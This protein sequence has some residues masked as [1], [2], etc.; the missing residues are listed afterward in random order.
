MSVFNVYS[1]KCER[2]Q[3]LC[4]VPPDFGFRCGGG[5]TCHRK[6]RNMAREF[7]KPFYNS[8]EWKDLRSF[9]LKRDM[10]LCAKCG[11]PAE[12]V[13]H[14]IHLSP[15]NIG[16]LSVT[17]NPDNLISLCRDCHFDEHKI[18]KINGS[19]A[20]RKSAYDSEEYYF[21]ENGMLQK[22]HTSQSS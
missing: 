19:K 13:H 17:M 10:Y 3:E 6:R 21:D 14:K 11:K 1:G 20:K 5:E 8:K 2:T 7:S 4:K 9:I 16:D 12:E 18:D 15:K 22:R